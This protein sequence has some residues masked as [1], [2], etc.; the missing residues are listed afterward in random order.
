MP[1][2]KSLPFEVTR[3]QEEE[4]NSL[5][6]L[7]QKC[8]IFEKIYLGKEIEDETARE[9]DL[10]VPSNRYETAREEEL[11]VVSKT[12]GP[13]GNDIEVHDLEIETAHET[14]PFI[15]R[16]RFQIEGEEKEGRNQTGRT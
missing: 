12:D 8:K 9:E 16:V 3:I 14:P 5:W 10:Q 11:V 1:K 13:D 4:K 2:M 6:N 7:R 15:R